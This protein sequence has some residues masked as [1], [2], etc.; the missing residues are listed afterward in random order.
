MYM[1]NVS[2]GKLHIS[3][4]DKFFSKKKKKLVLLCGG[5]AVHYP[6]LVT[7]TINELMTS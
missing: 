4:T 2:W 1:V 5:A 6:H 3:F 7:A